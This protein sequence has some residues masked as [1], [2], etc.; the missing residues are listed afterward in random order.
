M[1]GRQLAVPVYVTLT[2]CRSV[3][4][5]MNSV[6]VIRFKSLLPYIL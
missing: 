2:H 5:L 4:L 6:Q 1:T 3:C